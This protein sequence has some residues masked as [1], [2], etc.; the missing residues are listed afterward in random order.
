VA[1]MI[2][3]PG[4]GHFF[5]QIG[6]RSVFRKFCSTLYRVALRANKIGD[7]YQVDGAAVFLEPPA[8]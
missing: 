6:N 7:V 1:E 8:A 5:A 2:G 4:F 3:N